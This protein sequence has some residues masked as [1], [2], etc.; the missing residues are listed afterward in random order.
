MSDGTRSKRALIAAL[1]A[2]RI[3]WKIV[4]KS[5]AH[6]HTVMFLY[7]LWVVWSRAD[8]LKVE[9]NEET[10]AVLCFEIKGTE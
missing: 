9:T 8:S 4:Q 3:A 1:Q 7:V 2:S 5:L 6:L 10:G